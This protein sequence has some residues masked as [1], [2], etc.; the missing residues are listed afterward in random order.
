MRNIIYRLIKQAYGKTNGIIYVYLHYCTTIKY[1]TDA[2][3][4][5]IKINDNIHLCVMDVYR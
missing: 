1:N 3:S 2:L 4:Y 5:Y